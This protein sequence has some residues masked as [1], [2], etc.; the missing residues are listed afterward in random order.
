[1][2]A[3]RDH[4][5]TA[6]DGGERRL[7]RRRL[8]ARRRPRTARAGGEFEQPPA[9]RFVAGSSRIDDQAEHLAIAIRLDNSRG[10]LKL[11]RD[12]S[13]AAGIA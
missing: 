12:D 4:V 7:E 2:D 11:V 9:R 6:G 13:S 10:G 3:A 5:G 1:M 8:G